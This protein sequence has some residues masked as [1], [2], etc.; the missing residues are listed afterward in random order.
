MNAVITYTFNPCVDKSLEIDELVPDKKMRCSAPKLEPGGGGINVAR[1]IH[2]L[3]GKVLAVFPSGGYHGS[4]LT[5]LLRMEGVNS[6]PVPML[7]DIRENINIHEKSTGRQ[8]R[9]IEPGS[10][11]AEHSWTKCLD[12][13]TGLEKGGI[14][15]V[16]GSL[17]S[18]VPAD[19]WARI[20]RLTE[21]KAARLVVDVAGADLREAL[22]GG[23][24]FLIK[25]SEDELAML[26]GEMGLRA[27]RQEEVAQDIINRGWAQVVVV[28]RG[29]GGVLLVTRD[30]FAEIAA[31]VVKRKSTVGAGDSLVAGIVVGLGRKMEMVEAVRFGVACGAAAV[32]N[33]GTELCHP[34]DVEALYAKMQGSTASVNTIP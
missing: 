29:A 7:A 19:L 23:G 5:D 17:P 12:V 18:G 32:M 6:Y 11:L 8:Y 21:R 1:V 16:S 25:P 26:A 9:L 28:S 33:P 31:P 22:G 27:G 2:R 10:P 15:V 34:R 20:R 4:L 30:R 14:V 24:V 13:L 3:G